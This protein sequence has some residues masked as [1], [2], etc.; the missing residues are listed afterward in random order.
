[1]IATSLVVFVEN[2]IDVIVIQITALTSAR[3]AEYVANLIVDGAATD[4]RF[5]LATKEK[6][7]QRAVY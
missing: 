7:Q 2:E 3:L 6:V 1:M 5:R 4:E